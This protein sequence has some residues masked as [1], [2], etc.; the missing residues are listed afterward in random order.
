[1][2]ANSILG[3]TIL[4]KKYSCNYYIPSSNLLFAAMSNDE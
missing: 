2:C 3:I 4:H 1:M